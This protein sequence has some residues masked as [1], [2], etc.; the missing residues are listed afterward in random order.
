MA[1]LFRRHINTGPHSINGIPRAPEL[2]VS[3][4]NHAFTPVQATIYKNDL[5]QTHFQNHPL[6]QITWKGLGFDPQAPP[7]NSTTANVANP[8]IRDYYK[9]FLLPALI[10]EGDVTGV[11]NNHGIDPGLDL[12]NLIYLDFI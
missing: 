9:L 8:S 5:V 7:C 12:D 11:Q 3:F 2:I 6:D 1:Y 10:L 4:G